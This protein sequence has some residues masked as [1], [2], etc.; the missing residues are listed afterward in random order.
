MEKK[1]RSKTALGRRGERAALRYMKKQGCKKIAVNRH[2]GR[3]ELDLILRDGEQTVFVEVKTRTYSEED[4]KRYG[5]A[6]DAVDREKKAH[7]LTAVRSYIKRHPDSAFCRIDVIEVY[8]PKSY[9]PFT[10]PRIHHIRNAI[11]ASDGGYRR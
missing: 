5:S 11:G 8:Y 7:I 2:V 9:G 6:A 10:R 4:I 1:G 3:N